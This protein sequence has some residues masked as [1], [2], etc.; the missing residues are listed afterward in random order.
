MEMFAAVTA[1]VPKMIITGKGVWIVALVAIAIFAV[2]ALILQYHW[3][4]YGRN[5]EAIRDIRR[6]FL[7]GGVFFCGIIFAAAFSYSL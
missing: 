3:N 5:E 7:F 6:K 1:A 2:S 4:E